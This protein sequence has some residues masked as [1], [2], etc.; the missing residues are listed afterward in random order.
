[1]ET[2]DD[3]EGSRSESGANT[4]EQSDA[5]TEPVRN[6]PAAGGDAM[7]T[8]PDVVPTQPV[9]ATNNADNTIVT[10]ATFR[11]GMTARFQL[12]S[13]S[14]GQ[15][16]LIDTPSMTIN[17]NGLDQPTDVFP[18][19]IPNA[20]VE[21]VNVSNIRQPPPPQRD[22]SVESRVRR[23]RRGEDRQRDQDDASSEASSED[24]ENPYWASFK[25]DTSSPDERELK[26]IEE[27]EKNMSTATD[28]EHWEDTTFEPLNDPE[29][30]PADVGRITW[31][32]KGVHG[33][34][35]KPNRETVMRSPSVQIGEY[36]WHLKFYP[37]G[38][39]G[40]EQVSVYVE[41]SPTRYED[42][43]K[44][45]DKEDEKKDEPS[46]SS[47]DPVA[48]TGA[49]SNGDADQQQ[50]EAG[51]SM[52][53]DDVSAAPMN[54]APPEV[55]QAAAS[56][57]TAVEDEKEHAGEQEEEK[58][59][60]KKPMRWRV[61]AQVCCV[62]YNPNEPRVYATQK[63][64]HNYCNDNPDWGWTRFHGP[65]DDLHQ[66]KRYQ[67][68]AILRDDTLAFTVYIRTVTD[69]TN[70]LWWHPAKDK[71][72]DS[73]EMT[74]RRGFRCSRPDQPSAVIA[75]FAFWCHFT[76]FMDII[77]NYKHPDVFYESDK[78]PTPVIEELRNLYYGTSD[79]AHVHPHAEFN[80]SMVA[81][82]MDVNS[83]DGI[84]KM[85]V[86]AFWEQVRRVMTMEVSGGILNDIS[87]A[88]EQ[89]LDMP[90]FK[91]PDPFSEAS[92]ESALVFRP[93]PR[94]DGV[95]LPKS[96]QPVSVQEIVD[97]ASLHPEKAFVLWQDFPNQKYNIPEH[98]KVVQIELRRQHYDQSSRG[99]MK[100]G[101]SVTID[102]HIVWSNESYTLYG[103]V[104]HSGSLESQEFYAVVRPE[105]PGNKW[106]K[107]APE[108]CTRRVQ[109]LTSMQ[110]VYAH[111]G[112][113]EPVMERSKV[114]VMK[115]IAPVAYIAAYVRTNEIKN[116]LE[117]PFDNRAHWIPKVPAPPPEETDE[118]DDEA[119]EE[120]PKAVAVDFYCGDTFSGQNEVETFD[121]WSGRLKEHYK[122][123]A[124]VFLPEDTT[125]R[126]IKK[127]LDKQLQEITPEDSDKVLKIWLLDVRRPCL[128]SLPSFHPYEPHVDR[129]LEKAPQ[130]HEG[131]KFWLGGQDLGLLR[132]LVGK[133]KTQDAETLLNSIKEE[134]KSSDDQPAT[135][136]GS[137]AGT[138]NGQAGGAAD[139][140]TT[141]S[142][143]PADQ[144]AAQP[145]EQ[146][147]DG[148]IVMGDTQ[149]DA[150]DVPP[151]PQPA[152]S[153][154]TPQAPQSSA[155]APVQELLCFVKVFD[156][157]SQTLTST[158]YFSA[159]YRGNVQAEVKKALGIE[160]KE[161]SEDEMSD[162]DPPQGE[163]DIYH[164]L[165]QFTKAYDIVPSH[166]VIENYMI[167]LEG[168]G[169]SREMVPT[170]GVCF[171]AQRRPTPEQ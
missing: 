14:P 49:V 114:D 148:D 81:T 72:W 154:A 66:R 21:N 122:D 134:T 140:N 84:K 32:C 124:L 139:A 24:E 74:G 131:C 118:K 63:S 135:A 45:G 143:Q 18:V 25:E 89:F 117:V 113:G 65:W 103:V 3:S 87:K 94:I 147:T 12:N 129:S 78:R 142:E 110:A 127:I 39:E 71:V 100:L 102:E 99:W 97:L 82:L 171:I 156:F 80:L 42:E 35:D 88:P 136:P 27:S 11:I 68:S 69:P 55:S 128:G 4:P 125:V 101:H 16:T 38:N 146:S 90:L 144:T 15:A 119:A 22:E 7:D 34:P 155:P 31:V 58:K 157:E 132:Q 92:N 20:T 9:A 91:Q 54:G 166:A 75:A 41:C 126:D 120:P 170:D 23:E 93:Q 70:C 61:P 165:F 26:V 138:S 2:D 47:N 30:V 86:I 50:A 37:R 64:T 169:I 104:V 5:T 149:N 46:S 164:E 145:A 62:M 52:N 152:T 105:G 28:H 115:E 106:L 167:S 29:Y 130:F 123:S 59:E 19:V 17:L 160:N 48:E 111:Q 137:P 13:P 85:D 43:D 151:P 109:F 112:Q 95:P 73:F 33:T 6:Q 161:K 10:H 57:G 108:N 158:T 77:R 153:D 168:L 83:M 96:H 98:P 56:T 162:A 121:P 36:F 150:V 79:Y 141:T 44:K 133:L 76:P 60:D 116:A 163:W 1:M 159:P 53:T 67:R 8:S 40:T 51:E 107:F